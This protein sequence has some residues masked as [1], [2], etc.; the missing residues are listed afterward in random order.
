VVLLV[1]QVKPVLKEIQECRVK[2]ELKVPQALVHRDQLGLKVG[3]QDQLVQLD[4]VDLPVNVDRLVP[5]VH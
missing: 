5:V 2:L 4:Q 3:H 1:G